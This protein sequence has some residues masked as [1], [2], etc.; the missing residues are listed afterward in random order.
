MTR[1]AATIGLASVIIALLLMITLYYAHTYYAAGMYRLAGQYDR[2]MNPYGVD[3]EAPAPNDTDRAL[4]RSMF[5]ADLHADTLK[6][7]R[8]L[9][10]RSA[11]GHV[12]APRLADGNVSLQAFTI[13]TRSPLRMPWSNSLS[14]S[15][16]D[17]YAILS[18]L[19]GRPVRD[20]RARA[21]HQI[22]RFK[23]AVER[24]RGNPDVP[25]LRLIESADDLE[26]LAEDR[27][28]GEN[29]IGGILGIEGGHWIGGRNAD[30]DS[31]RADMQELFD[32]GVRMFAANHRF[33]NTLSGSSE[34]KRRYGLTS[35]GMTALETAESLGMMVD[36]A[37]ISD[38]GLVDAANLLEKPFLNSHT[39]IQSECVDPCLPD[40][41]L[42]D[43]D[44]RLILDGGGVVGVGFWPQA[45]G[46]SVWR[47]A[48][49]MA[50][51]KRIAEEMGIEDPSRHVAL[52]SDYDGSVTPMIEVS[53]L[54]VLTTILRRQEYPFTEEQIRNI[55]GR[56]V[57]RVFATVLPGGS[58]ERASEVCDDL[59]VGLPLTTNL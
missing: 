55:A 56:N 13:V 24:S 9:L 35:H 48:D 51:I 5:V 52:G 41:N 3:P 7:D 36:V 54:D 2:M 45:I 20:L 16:L 14:G 27:R 26:A 50:H 17:T 33:D 15:S 44:I 30:H 40:R 31:V 57:C 28:A 32:A 10:S 43:E 6:W 8:D 34:G 53:H 29:V 11:F 21:F 46:P 38:A 58:E 12:D 18:F 42:S 22:E 47:V 25:E 39:G 4:H 23:A 19:Q 1:R 59:E 49:V 37:H